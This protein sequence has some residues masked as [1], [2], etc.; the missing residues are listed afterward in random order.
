MLLVDPV[1]TLAALG[2][3][4]L[5]GVSGLLHRACHESPDRVLLPAHLLHD[6]GQRRPSFPLQHRHHLGRLAASASSGRSM[7]CE[8]TV[9]PRTAL[10]RGAFE[11]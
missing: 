8:Y 1:G 11:F 7:N 10:P 2:F 4:R 3:E 6:L 9:S 5:D